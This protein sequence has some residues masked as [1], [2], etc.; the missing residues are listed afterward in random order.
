MLL[1]GTG[2]VGAVY[3]YLLQK[4]GAEVTAVCRSNYDAAK[5]NGFLIN[6]TKYGDVRINPE[7]IRQPSDATGSWDFVVVC[8]KSM[9]GMKP[10]QPDIIKS[11]VGRDTAIVLIQNGIAIEDEYAELFPGNPILSCVTYLPVTQTSPGVIAH[12]E[13][14]RLQIGT[15]PADGASAQRK[16]HEF[17]EIM[18]AGGGNVEVYDDIQA[19]R[20]SKLVVNAAWNPITALTRSRDAYFLISS[21]EA[22]NTVHSVMLEVASVAQAA[23]YTRIDEKLVEYQLGRAKAREVPGVEPSMMADALAHRAMEVEAIMGNT[24]KIAKR[25]NVQTPLLKA[26]YVL[27]KALDDSFAREKSST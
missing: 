23:G 17:V 24:I 2:S 27:A 6:S 8:A 14:E 1:F 9:P 5:A 13:V 12:Y 18:R 22:L 16:L 25:H 10:S 3:A 20:W 15:F 7:V 19:E 26:I 21:P 4:G 11:A